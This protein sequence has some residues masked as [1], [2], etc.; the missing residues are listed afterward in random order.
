M[1]EKI[2]LIEKLGRVEPG[3][4]YIQFEVDRKWESVWDQIWFWVE[5]G[6]IICQIDE[7][8]DEDC[9]EKLVEMFWFYTA[10]MMLSK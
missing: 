7:L 6:K 3:S 9:Q 5:D 1:S 10:L 8:L 4:C 2:K